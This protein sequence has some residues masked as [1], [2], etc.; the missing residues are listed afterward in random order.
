VR[1]APLAEI[2]QHIVEVS[3]NEGAE[4]LAHQVAVAQGRPA[5]FAGAAVAV[6][7]ALGRLGISTAGDRIYDGS[8]LSRDD[9]LRADTLLAVIRTASADRHP[10]LRSAVA[11]LPV[12]G[13]TGSLAARFD[14]GNPLGLGRVRA[15][16]GTLTGVH[17]LAGTV[18]T[19][20]G[21]VLEFV[22]V[23]DKVRPV[24]T[25][26]ARARLDELAAAL[27]GCACTNTP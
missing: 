16:T 18:T 19:R 7:H 4:V 26:D 22:A 27:A 20:D 17:G 23:A 14:K 24:N 21:A 11:D 15:K 10:G 5:T 1:S 8:G 12:A 3:D 9:R 6:R 2:V 25:L 13:F